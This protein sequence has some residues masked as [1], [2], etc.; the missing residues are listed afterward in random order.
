MPLPVAGKIHRLF[1]IHRQTGNAAHLFAIRG[2]AV[3]FPP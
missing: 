2:T 3:I 1:V